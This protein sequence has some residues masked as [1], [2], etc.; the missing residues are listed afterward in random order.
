MEISDVNALVVGCPECGAVPGQGCIEFFD[1]GV[2]PPH[3]QRVLKAKNSG[4]LV[5]TQK[6]RRS[7]GVSSGPKSV[8][9]LM[10]R[11]DHI[12]EQGVCT[13][14]GA[15]DSSTTECPVRL[16]FVLDNLVKRA[17]VRQDFWEALARR[18]KDE[19]P[20]QAR[21]LED[22]AF[23]ARY[24]QWDV[25]ILSH[26]KELNGEN[27]I[28]STEY[29]PYYDEVVTILLSEDGTRQAIYAPSVG[30]WTLLVLFGGSSWREN[31]FHL[32]RKQ[33]KGMD[34]VTEEEA[35][36]W[37]ETGHPPRQ[38]WVSESTS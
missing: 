20:D 25:D 38:E 19:N 12:F 9:D 2:V 37:V 31:P 16:R 24:I 10:M 30:E 36:Y 32:S 8:G 7:Q 3:R 28:R 21:S 23:I 26:G 22:M 14:C 27:L 5:R 13:K 34:P 15:S 11:L 29:H 35:I 33:M 4:G 6:R 1:V 18:V 17:K